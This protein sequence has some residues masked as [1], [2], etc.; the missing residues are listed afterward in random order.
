MFFF[1]VIGVLLSGCSALD[2]EK[3]DEWP[4]K[5]QVKIKISVEPALVDD[6]FNLA[7][8]YGKE[9]DGDFFTTLKDGR[10]FEFESPIVHR[11]LGHSMWITLEPFKDFDTNTKTC[12]RFEVVY[13]FAGK[14]FSSDSREVGKSEDF[15]F[16]CDW[17]SVMFIEGLP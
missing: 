6:E 10:Y 2:E 15:S 17:E 14:K 12:Y 4:D 16:L 9:G 11:N 8:F 3:E 1:A 13:E 5:G 7:W